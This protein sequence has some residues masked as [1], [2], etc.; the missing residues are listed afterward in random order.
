MQTINAYFNFMGNTEEA[1]NFYRSVF[2]GEFT[3]FTRFKELP[4]SEQI[5]APRTKQDHAR[6]S[7][8]KK[9]CQHYGYR[10]PGIYGAKIRTRNGVNLCIQAESEEEVEKLFKD[11]SRGGK[12][13]MPLNKTFWGAYFGMCKDK[14]G[15]SW[16]IN[17][18][19][20]QNQ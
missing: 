13:D 20:P 9:R 10:F 7:H 5:P 8:Y 6:H 14:F 17:Y 2:G 1:M 12:V 15:V 11:L 19:Y 3:A 16:M 18:T 4:G